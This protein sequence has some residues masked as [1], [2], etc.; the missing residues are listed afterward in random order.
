[1]T[2]ILQGT[3]WLGTIIVLGPPGKPP[4]AR[5]ASQVLQYS[6]AVGFAAPPFLIREFCQQP[7]MLQRLRT[8]EFVQWAG[9]PLDEATGNALCQHVTLCPAFGTTECGPYV[10]NICDDLV[11]WPYLWFRDGQGIELQPRTDSLFELVFRKQSGAF[12]QQIFILYPELEVYATKDL[13]QKHPS[14]DYLWLYSG[15]LDD[16]VILSNG[17]NV[18]VSNMEEVIMRHPAIQQALVGG[19]GRNRPFLILQLADNKY[20]Q[21]EDPNTLLSSVWPAVEAANESCPEFAK[22]SKELTIFSSP[23]K[24]FLQAAKE[25]LRRRETLALYEPEID[26]LYMKTDT[27]DLQAGDYVKG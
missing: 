20:V 12:W 17:Q 3:V 13:F 4:L 23:K 18:P 15:R 11:D 2:A 10:T 16:M 1:M 22:L 21:A 14:K 25:S 8:M 7:D 19:E 9:A 5:I 24:P 26:A 6:G 27:S